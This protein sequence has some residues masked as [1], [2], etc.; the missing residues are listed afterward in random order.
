MANLERMVETM[1]RTLNKMDDRL[2]RLELMMSFLT[3]KVL[4]AQALGDGSDSL[5]DRCDKCRVKAIQWEWEDAEWT[6]RC[7]ACHASGVAAEDD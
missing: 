4:S 5:P 6:Y 7:R 2:A 3:N 1:S